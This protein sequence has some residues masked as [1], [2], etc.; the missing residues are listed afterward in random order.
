MTSKKITFLGTGAPDATKYFNSCFYIKEGATGLLIDAGGGNQIL[1][2]L[3][4]ANI[5]L[6]EIRHIY[7]T[8]KHIDHIF[9]LFWILRFLGSKISK[10]KAEG[11]TIFCSQKTADLI[12]QVSLIFLKRKVTDLFDRKIIFDI[13]E[14]GKEIKIGD[15]KIKCFNIQSA[16]EE[17]YGFRLEFSD[18]T[19]FVCLGDEP[20][21]N[22]VL[23]YAKNATYLLHDAFCLDRD[24]DIFEPY[25]MN[26]STAKS[27]G[28]NAAKIN[29]QNLILFHT[30]DKTTFGKRKEL[31][32]RD[33]EKYFAGKIFVP[34]DLEVI[35]LKG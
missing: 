2:Q 26:H 25:K 18:G 4:K 11:L 5:P 1:S 6:E 34:D 27:A 29:A 9:G 31:Y 17:Q 22:T 15:W 7:I 20:Y 21:N 13:L 14:D 23:S 19:S 28:E 24:K 12:K 8:H 33:A 32:K 3:E 10:G 16:K 35:E 30:E